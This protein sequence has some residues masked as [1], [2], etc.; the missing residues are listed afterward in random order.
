MKDIRSTKSMLRTSFVSLALSAVVFLA[1]GSTV[2]AQ[3]LQIAEATNNKVT[4]VE[5]IKQY[6]GM[7]E[8]QEPLSVLT[9]PEEAKRMGIEGRVVLRY[10][11]DMQGKAT[12]IQVLYGLGYGC[13]EEAIRLLKS[14][15]FKPLVNEN[16]D[17]TSRE[18]TTPL[19]F[20]L[21]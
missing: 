8:L 3:D 13:D 1:F 14:A 5:M 11:V 9:Y 15:H 20:K 16:G 7:P 19:T 10:T 12:D 2:S 21:R 4:K 17:K 6:R 18:F